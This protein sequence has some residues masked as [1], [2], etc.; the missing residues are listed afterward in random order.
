VVAA[1]APKPAPKPYIS[2]E[3]IDDF[4]GWVDMPLLLLRDG[5]DDG[6]Q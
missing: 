2:G 6:F 5:G 4:R 1:P 3:Q